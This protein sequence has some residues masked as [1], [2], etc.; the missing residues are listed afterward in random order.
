MKYNEI[1]Q[2]AIIISPK[3]FTRWVGGVREARLDIVTYYND[4]GGLASTL[5]V[6][7]RPSSSSF[8][9]LLVCKLR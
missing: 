4:D 9:L 3:V 1:Y 5:Y 7:L 6:L 2:T 8:A